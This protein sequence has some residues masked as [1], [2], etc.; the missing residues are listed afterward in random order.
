MPRFD[1]TISGY[2]EW[3]KRVQLYARRLELQG[4]SK[5]V[6]MNV[7]AVLEGSSWT[8]CEDIDLKELEAENGL[9]VLLRRLDSKWKYDERV[10]L[11]SIF[12]TFFFKVQ[13]KPNQ[14]LLDY[15]TD[16][17]QALRDVQRL[18]VDLP[19]EITGWLMLRRAALTKDQQHLVQSQVGKTLTLGN[20]EQSLFLVFGQDFKQSNHQSHRG[21]SFPKGKGRSNVHHAEDDEHEFQ[22]DWNENYMDTYYENDDDQYYECDEEWDE[23]Y[24]GSQV[25]WSPTAS[26]WN[27]SEAAVEDESL[28]DVVEFD[29]VYSAYMPMPRADLHSCAKAV[30]STRLW[31]WW[32]ERVPACL[33]AGVVQSLKAKVRRD[34]NNHHIHQRERVSK[35]EEKP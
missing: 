5:E 28:F 14:S 35:L 16:F 27:P 11:G 13:R 24:F 32:T 31:R 7:L 18:K 21:K 30:A 12:D 19:E 10:E 26:E 2:K 9:D 20:V 33:K 4:R 3:R 6:A 25:D 8:Q 34:P 22:D 29:S 23:T 17:H 15:V 1:N